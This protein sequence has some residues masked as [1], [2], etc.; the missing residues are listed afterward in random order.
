MRASGH[1]L[2]TNQSAALSALN[3]KV[4]NKIG[5]EV[6]TA[7]NVC[8]WSYSIVPL[9]YVLIQIELLKAPRHRPQKFNQLSAVVGSEELERG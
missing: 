4:V 7:G 9:K 5:T 6:R 2:Q 1:L 3:A 8:I